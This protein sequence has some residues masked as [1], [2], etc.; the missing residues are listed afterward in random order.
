MRYEYT[1]INETETLEFIARCERYLNSNW[2]AQG[3]VAMTWITK[4]DY[5]YAIYAQAFIREVPEEGEK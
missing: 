5:P 1:V 3:G 2:K 4:T